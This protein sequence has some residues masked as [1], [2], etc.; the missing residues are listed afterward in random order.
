MKIVSVGD[1]EDAEKE[2]Y[3]GECGLVIRCDTREELLS[4]MTPE[5][6]DKLF[7]DCKLKL[8]VI[9]CEVNHE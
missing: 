8:S 4:L 5:I 2:T 6:K 1:W 3:G 7:Q 9:D